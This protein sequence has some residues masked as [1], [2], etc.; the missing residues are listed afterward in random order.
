MCILLLTLN[1]SSFNHTELSVAH[2]QNGN[3]I[4]REKKKALF[5]QTDFYL[6]GKKDTLVIQLRWTPLS[7]TT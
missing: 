2:M 1:Q 3:A 6:L 5:H 7:S 4:E